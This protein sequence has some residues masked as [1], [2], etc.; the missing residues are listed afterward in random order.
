MKKMTQSRRP[1]W[2]PQ[3]GTAGNRWICLNTRQVWNQFTTWWKNFRIRCRGIRGPLFSS[4]PPTSLPLCMIHSWSSHSNLL[5]AI[6]LPSLKRLASQTRRSRSN[7]TTV[8]CHSLGPVTF[9][10]I[11]SSTT[12]TNHI[13]ARS[14][15]ASSRGLATFKNTCF[16]IWEAVP[17]HQGLCPSLRCS[18]SWHVNKSKTFSSKMVKSISAVCAQKISRAS[19]VWRH[20][21]AC[22]RERGHMSAR[23]AHLHSLRHVLWRCTCACILGRNLTS[24]RNAG[25]LSQE[26][27]RCTLTCT[28]TKVRPTLSFNVIPLI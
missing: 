9:S 2:N 10:A 17:E 16:H 3:D 18:P 25:A 22:T 27:T 8:W 19:V 26:G 23:C 24:A 4:H 12:T 5:H 20:I 13:S 28:F 1:P 6:P 7:A 21:F 15:T 14:V 11:C